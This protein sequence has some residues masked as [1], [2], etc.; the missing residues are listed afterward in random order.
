MMLDWFI[1]TVGL[2][3]VVVALARAPKPACLA[4]VNVL[5]SVSLCAC[6]GLGIWWHMLL[7]QREMQAR[8]LTRILIVQKFSGGVAV[9]SP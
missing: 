1:L 2:V 5:W 7:P 3:A 9:G 8:N 4:F 6:G